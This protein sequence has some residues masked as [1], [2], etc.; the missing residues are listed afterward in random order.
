MNSK[1]KA[2]RGLSTAMLVSALMDPVLWESKEKPVKPEK[3]KKECPICHKLHDK[4][5][6]CCTGDCYR[7]MVKRQKAGSPRHSN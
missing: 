5:R 3:P 2:M 6:L 4:K 1:G 7:E